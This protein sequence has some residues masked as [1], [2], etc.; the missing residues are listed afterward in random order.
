LKLFISNGLPSEVINSL[1]IVWFIVKLAMDWIVSYSR[2][3]LGLY[4]FVPFLNGKTQFQNRIFQ[5]WVIKRQKHLQTFK[6]ILQVPV[7]DTNCCLE[8]CCPLFWS[9][10]YHHFL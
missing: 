4:F 3:D 7:L 5:L 8:L 10:K 2:T 1:F 9:Y 6:D